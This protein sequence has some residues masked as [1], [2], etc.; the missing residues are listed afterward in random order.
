MDPILFGLLISD[1]S[2]TL[3]ERN[4]GKVSFSNKQEIL[5]QIF[6]E[7]IRQLASELEIQPKIRTRTHKNGVKE[8][9][10]ENSKIARS[11]L[12]EANSFITRACTHHPICPTLKGKNIESSK[13]KEHIIV[14]GTPFHVIKIPSNI[15]E[16]EER[17]CEMLR[18][19]CSGDGQ[20]KLSPTIVNNSLALT[21]RVIIGCVHPQL[22]KE[23]I[24]CF[25]KIGIVA[26]EGKDRIII[27]G[28][29]NLE[30]FFEKV[31]FI[32]GCKVFNGLWKGF[33]KNKV[34]EVL[35]N[36]FGLNFKNFHTKIELINFLRSLMESKAPVAGLVC[37]R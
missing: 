3:R 19:L 24:S 31:G 2:V 12:N 30:K 1:G 22:R 32:D 35:I 36:S 4:R 25:L 26:K 33:D 29:D 20:V 15:L 27:E 8:T 23:I 11:L 37:P 21:R 10:I 34:L 13:E 16:K 9:I 6:L 28:K 5:H 7:K 18:A 14:N 17:I